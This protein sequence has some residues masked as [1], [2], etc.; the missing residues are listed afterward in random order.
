MNVYP[1]FQIDPKLLEIAGQ[2]E[3][4]AQAQF[5]EIEAT[6]RYNQQKMLAAFIQAGVS[7]SHFVGS[8]GYG[9][10]DRGRDVL[11]QVYAYAFGAEDALVRHNFVSGTHTLTVALFG[12]L[13]PG[14]KM[15]CV[16]GT[17]Y[18]TIQGVIGMEGR[19]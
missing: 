7:E 13:R 18:D 3:E 19:E 16:T 6:Q 10:G 17:P 15:L 4:L 1:T 8:T 5:Q 12:M 9:Y 14:D 2:A 11:D